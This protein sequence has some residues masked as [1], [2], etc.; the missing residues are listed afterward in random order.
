MVGYSLALSV[1]LGCASSPREA[2][3]QR[4]RNRIVIAEI[5]RAHHTSTFEIVQQ[6]RPHWLRTRGPD[7]F[8]SS[9]EVM[10]YIDNQLVGGVGHL[11][12][13]A[14]RSVEQIVYLDSREATQ[15]FGTGHISGAILVIT[16]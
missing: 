1:M 4:N 9:N 8:R 12:D 7:S 16:R 13:I 15:R 6:M 10:V 11:R 2:G 14:A 5:E 3:E